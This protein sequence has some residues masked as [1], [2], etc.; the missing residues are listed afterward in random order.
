MA[1]AEEQGAGGGERC[2]QT[3]AAQ[4]RDTGTF[5]TAKQAGAY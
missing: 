3:A 4:V 2:P 1:V 5:Q